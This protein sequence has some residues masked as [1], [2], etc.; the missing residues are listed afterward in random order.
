MRFITKLGFEYRELG[1]TR[2][3]L[4][5]RMGVAIVIGASQHAQRYEV[6]LRELGYLVCRVAILRTQRQRIRLACVAKSLM[7]M[8]ERGML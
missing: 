4:H 6:S 8:R 3:C 5:D 7:E 1:A 2:V